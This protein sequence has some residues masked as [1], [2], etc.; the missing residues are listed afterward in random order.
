MKT[1]NQLPKIDEAINDLNSADKAEAVKLE[2][3][4]GFTFN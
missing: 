3:K 4:T 1:K 2:T